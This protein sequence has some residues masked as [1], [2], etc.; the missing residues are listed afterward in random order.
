MG[1][2]M[3]TDPV[4][5][6]IVINKELNMS[7]GK[8]FAQLGHLYFGL[9]NNL[10]DLASFP[11]IDHP[12]R[13]SYLKWLNTGTT[14][15][16]LQ[17]NSEQINKLVNDIKNGLDCCKLGVYVIDEGRTEVPENSITI[18]GF[19]PIEKSMA[20]PIIKELKLYKD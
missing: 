12:Y 13:E 7:N 20:H 16:V 4:V 9:F 17:A 5:M 3:H 8:I 6:Y 10:R 15:V 18:V 14:K 1:L 2:T 11:P 19:R